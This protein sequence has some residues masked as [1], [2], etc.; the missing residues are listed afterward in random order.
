MSASVFV[1]VCVCVCVCA[2]CV[3]MR[4]VL[5]YLCA[6]GV[7]CVY[8][9]PPVCASRPSERGEVEESTIG[10]EREVV[11]PLLLRILILLAGLTALALSLPWNLAALAL[12]ALALA[13]LG[14]R[15]LGTSQPWNLAAL[16][17]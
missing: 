12:A 6:G 17:P 11:V 14:P 5:T 7:L 3:R 9:C 8:V 4:Y 2:V 13:S 1:C 10:A 16:A 15:C